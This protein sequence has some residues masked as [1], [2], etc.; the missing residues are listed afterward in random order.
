MGQFEE[1]TREINR[2]GLVRDE[3]GGREAGEEKIV[4]MFLELVVRCGPDHA[5]PL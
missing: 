2:T 3:N 4:Q 1:S 5:F